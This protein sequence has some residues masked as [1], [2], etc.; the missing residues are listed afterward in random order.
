[1]STQTFKTP[2]DLINDNAGYQDYNNTWSA[3]KLLQ[4]ESDIIDLQNDTVERAND[5]EIKAGINTDKTATVSKQ[6][7]AVFYGLAK[8]SGDT[9]QASSVNSVGTYTENAKSAIS[10]MLNAPE[11]FNGSTLNAKPGVRYVLG[12]IANLDIIAP[13]TGCVDVIFKSGN[14]PTVLTVTSAK[15]NTTIKFPIWFSSIDANTWYE[16]N[17]LDGEFGVVGSWM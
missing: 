13:A 15:P 6:H 16:I 1:M 11:N 3:H 5:S 12:E 17:I 7:Q 8:A 10:E 9:T 14:T 2:G 4:M